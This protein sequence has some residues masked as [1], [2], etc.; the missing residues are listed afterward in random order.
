V[1]SSSNPETAVPVSLTFTGTARQSRISVPG[2]A[3][4]FVTSADYANDELYEGVAYHQEFACYSKA[5]I[6]LA[7]DGFAR[8]TDMQ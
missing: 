3:A 5:F 1:F 6:D 2:A 8:R 7:K 4:A